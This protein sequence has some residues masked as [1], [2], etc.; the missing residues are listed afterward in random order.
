MENNFTILLTGVDDSETLAR[1][2]LERSG[3]QIATIIPFKLPYTLPYN[4]FMGIQQFQLLNR[5]RPFLSEPNRTSAVVILD[6]SEWIGHE[7]EEYLTI[8]FRYLHDHSA[9]SFYKP[10]Y[11]LTLGSTT[12]KSA[13]KMYCLA[14]EYLRLGAMVQDRTL[15]DR[16]LLGKYLEKAYPLEAAAAD[17]LAG[18]YLQKTI[19]SLRHVRLM[20]EDLLSRLNGD[21]SPV[22]EK[23][24]AQAVGDSKLA[25]F[26]GETVQACFRQQ[27]ELEEKE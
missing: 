20:T 8:F 11:I 13:K 5:Y 21:A 22:T 3:K 27:G 24:L 15:Q 6:L 14:S 16:E 7:D 17:T 26:Y 23:Q 25:L 4:R 19:A 2:Y 1:A 9:T 18:I 10:E 12:A